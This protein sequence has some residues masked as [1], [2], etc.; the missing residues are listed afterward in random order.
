MLAQ[1][2]RKREGGVGMSAGRA[3]FED[4]PQ[5]RQWQPSTRPLRVFA[6]PTLADAFPEPIPVD[7]YPVAGHRLRPKYELHAVRFLEALGVRSADFEVKHPTQ[8]ALTRRGTLEKCAEWLQGMHAE[9]GTVYVHLPD[10]RALRLEGFP[11][12]RAPWPLRPH[13]ITE[14]VRGEF[15]LYWRVSGAGV[16]VARLPGFRNAGWLAACIEDNEHAPYAL[17]DFREAWPGFGY[18]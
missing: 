18:D 16:H 8:G 1:E 6:T 7:P 2:R 9:G 15:E 11:A 13:A 12:D 10:V 3:F 5:S 14:P 4:V 17:D